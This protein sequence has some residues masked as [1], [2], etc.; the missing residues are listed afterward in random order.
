MKKTLLFLIVLAV[1]IGS[2]SA[3]NKTSSGNQD[4]AADDSTTDEGSSNAGTSDGSNDESQDST[5]LKNT[6]EYD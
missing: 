6:L 4:A 5:L 3:C 1:V 2:I